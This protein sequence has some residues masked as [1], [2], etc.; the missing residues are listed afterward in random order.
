MDL[1]ALAEQIEAT[2][3]ADAIKSSNWAFPAIEAVHLLA[4]ATLGGAVAML[5]LRLLGVGLSAQPISLVERNA[6]PWLLSALAVMVAT[7]VTLALSEP[8]KLE[9]KT[10]FWVKMAALAAAIV[11]C[12]AVRGPL[13]RRDALGPL[14]ARLVASLS[15]ALWLSVALAGR[16]IG[17]S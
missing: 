8:V 12:L 16:W 9:G 5:D 7:G 11:F 2:P 3:V 10:A 4:L 1:Y 14:A 15:L 13:A 17:F 6:R